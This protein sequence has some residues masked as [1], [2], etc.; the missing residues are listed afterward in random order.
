MKIKLLGFCI[1]IFL[2]S[3]KEDVKNTDIV[4]KEVKQ[5]SIEQFMDNEAIGGGSFSYDNSQLLISSNRSGIYNAFTVSTEGGEMTAITQSDSTSVFGNAFFPEDNRILLSADGN[6]DEIDHLFVRDLEGNV[7]DITPEK[8]AKSDFYGWSKDNNSLYFGSNKRDPRFFDVYKMNLEDYTS[9]MIYQNNDGLDFSGMSDDENYFALSKTVNTNDSDLF[10]YNSKTKEKIQINENQSANSSQDFSKDNSIFYYTTDYGGEF[11]VLMSYN[12]ETK[13]NIKVLEKKWDISSAYFTKK[14]K[15]MV[16]FVNEDGKNAIEVLDSES[17]KPIDLPN[18]EG[19]SITSVGFSN[20]Q[21]LMR[22]YVGGS[23]APSDLYTYNFETKEQHQISDVLNKD[24]DA[25]DLVTAKVVRFESFDGTIIPAIYYL[26]HQASAENKVPAMV[27]VHGGPG[28]QTRQGFSSLI[29]YMVNQGYAVLAVNNRGSSGYGKTFYQMD[30]KNHGE[31]DLQDCIEG[32][33][34][35][36]GQTE[37][38]GD[39]I[40]IIGGSYGGYMTMAAL[41]YTPEEFAVG[42]NLFGVTNWMRTL[43]S[44]P[45]YWE[46]FRESLYKELGDPYSADSTRLKRISPLFHTDKVTKPLIVLQGAQDPRVLQVES[47]E[48]VAG[49]RKNNVP[50]EYVLFEDEGHGFVKKENQ[51]EANERIVKFLD[52]YLKKEGA[53]KDG[54][55]PLNEKIEAESN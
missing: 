50:V 35:L 49:V 24:I 43:K 5:Y 19:K 53:P 12:M 17:M 25:E 42:V 10:I 29:Q 37:I 1:A 54:Q 8:G 9:E 30:D 16:V 15:Y 46:S 18:F 22:M 55:E 26:P 44:I 34:W 20:D 13:E 27:W 39:K 47:D 40:G 32:K 38:D 48:I 21:K 4:K 14:N 28:G 31:K 3:C 33:N 36:A 7:T 51:I 41:T 11:S 2:F 45:P 23:N 52:K 6:G